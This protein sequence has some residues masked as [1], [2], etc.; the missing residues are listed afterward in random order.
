MFHFCN[1]AKALSDEN[2][3]RILMVLHEDPLCVCQLTSF[4]ELA[5]STT[6]K[7][8]SILRN[9]QL[10]ECKKSGRWAYYI[11]PKTP[12]NKTVENALE[13]LRQSLKDNPRIEEDKKRIDAIL[14]SDPCALGME[15]DDVANIHNL[16]KK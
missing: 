9:C 12:A 6:S 10:I 8:I 16:T 3:V 13:W 1:I 11:L 2:R 14:Q 15:K 5:P 7:H 4:L